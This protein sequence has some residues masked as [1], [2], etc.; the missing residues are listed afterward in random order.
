[1]SPS[2]PGI[3]KS[4][5]FSL[6]ECAEEI[7]QRLFTGYDEVVVKAEFGG[8]VGGGRVFLV[9]P[10]Q[11]GTGMLLAV[12]K[13]GPKAIINQ[14]WQ[15]YGRF[16]KN[17]LGDIAEIQDEPV[18]TA[19][20]TCGGL[21]YPLAGAGTFNVE[22]LEQ[23]CQRAS[24]EDVQHVLNK[25]LFS[26]LEQLW[27]STQRVR[28][29]F[30]LRDYYD[31]FLPVNLV[32]EPGQPPPS[33]PVYDLNPRIAGQAPINPGDYV[34]IFGFRVAKVHYG[35]KRLSLDLPGGK[36]A[37]YRLHVE[38]VANA[39]QYAVGT[40]IAV[41][42]RVLQTR[43]D[44]LCKQAQ[45]VMDTT[46][47]DQPEMQ[48]ADGLRLP[49]PLLAMP[50]V[51]RQTFDVYLAY[52]H[53]DL[54]LGNVLVEGENRNAYLIDFAKA[55]EDHVL[56]DFLHLELAVVTRLL[57]EAFTAAALSPQ[58]IVK[59]YEQL[60]CAIL[61]P[62]Q[63][64][65]PPQLEKPFSILKSIRLAARD[66]LHRKN[67][68][69]EYFCGLYIYLLGALK[70]RDLDELPTAPWPKQ[71]A[72]WG[73]AA[74]YNMLNGEP[75]CNGESQAGSQG[76]SGSSKNELVYTNTVMTEMKTYNQLRIRQF[77]T[78]RVDLKNFCFTLQH[79]LKPGYAH[80]H[81]DG[82]TPGE[83]SQSLLL[84]AEQQADVGEIVFQLVKYW[85]DQ[86]YG[87]ARVLVAEGLHEELAVFR[88]ELL[89][90]REYAK[91]REVSTLLKRLMPAA[92]TAIST[93]GGLSES[94]MFL[95]APS[96]R[97]HQILVERFNEEELRTFC[98]YLTVDYDSLGGE[99]KVGK[100]RELILYLDRRHLLSQLLAA[101][102]R[103]RPDIN[104]GIPD[105]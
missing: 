90:R 44:L 18:Y 66:Y 99:G 19:D 74:I 21:R 71:L 60:H 87:N 100:A 39:E 102:E 47:V 1:M 26:S 98:F 6:P 12:V 95:P 8:G 22:S 81:L 72:F 9:R 54:N 10:I 84:L 45:A 52:I 58:A 42:G 38:P 101:G 31:S 105:I 75:S 29:E 65:S 86:I 83:K 92:T 85:V 64:G 23:Y 15:A 13:I 63:V 7:L 94:S 34:N 46:D 68:W 14:E 73:A 51:L 82:N 30:S 53:G 103:L 55:R 3:R 2:K 33:T 36:E 78:N 11:T 93:T 61:N 27:K 37:A 67:N 69:N 80:R 24:L 59:F 48:L 5:Q 56:R 41:V 16:I 79:T 77:L 17:R 89:E 104:W 49:N 32:V 62:G 70:F 40:T 97:L 28:A 25:R 57:P 96:A 76:D 88:Q 43:A 20:E 35:Q 50:D 91:V 4:S